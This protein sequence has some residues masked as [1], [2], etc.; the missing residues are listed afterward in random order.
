MI[1]KLP[2]ELRDMIYGHM[3]ERPIS[4]SPGP[5]ESVDFPRDGVV[6]S[7]ISKAASTIDSEYDYDSPPED[8]PIRIQGWK[9]PMYLRDSVVGSQFASEVA[10]SWYR[11]VNLV[12]PATCVPLVIEDEIGALGSAGAP[13]RHIPREHLR[14]L[15][16]TF[17]HAVQLGRL[18]DPIP[19]TRSRQIRKDASSLKALLGPFGVKFK[20]GFDLQLCISCVR[21]IDLERWL[22]AL[23]PAI[24]A[25]KEEGFMVR[26]FQITDYYDGWQ[27]ITLHGARQARSRVMDVSRRFDRP[28]SDWKHRAALN[29]FL[30]PPVGRDCAGKQNRL[31]A[32]SQYDKPI[33]GP[34]DSRPERSCSCGRDD[35][36]RAP[37]LTVVE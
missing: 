1:T 23:G 8:P 6:I 13:A 11:H 16:V 35:C 21:E 3:Y 17:D 25:C 15:T 29:C 10:E 36:L 24:Y 4:H 34:W 20:K 37:C 31:L 30:A 2:R 14:Q 26:V 32:D 27:W 18:Q 9:L 19:W 33:H 5:F 12:M 7:W 28:F 22:E